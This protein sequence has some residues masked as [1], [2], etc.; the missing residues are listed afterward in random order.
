MS[1]SIA[2]AVVSGI[3]SGFCGSARRVMECTCAAHATM[4]TN[5]TPTT[6]FVWYPLRADMCKL[7]CMGFV[8]GSWEGSSMEFV[9]PHLKAAA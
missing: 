9:Y 8:T 5:T 3:S 4:A 6:S 7:S 1:V 2:P